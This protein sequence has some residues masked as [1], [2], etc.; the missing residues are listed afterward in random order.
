MDFQGGVWD[1]EGGEVLLRNHCDVILGYG[2]TWL[3]SKSETNNQ[4][5]LLERHERHESY[6]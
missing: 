6:S 1:K 3:K 4:W 5:T 2:V